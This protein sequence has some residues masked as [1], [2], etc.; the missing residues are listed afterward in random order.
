MSTLFTWNDSYSVKVGSLDKQHQKIFDIVNRLHG[1]MSS[2]KGQEQVK[3]AL[4][5]LID[6]TATHLSAEEAILEKQGY[7]NLAAHRSEHKALLEKVRAYQKEYLG[8]KIGM[9]TSVM[10]FVVD[11]LKHHI[12]QTDKQYSQFLNEHGVR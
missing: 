10:N 11:W 3:T 4:Q 2:G 6:Y 12:Q 8:G 1:T 7:P 9:A 5:E